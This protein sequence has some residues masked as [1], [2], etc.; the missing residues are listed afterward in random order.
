MCNLYANLM[1][2]DAMRQ[3][4]DG[5]SDKLGNQPSLPAIFPDMAV[6]ILRRTD[7]GER[8]LVQARWGYSKAKFGWVT[9]VR[10][11]KGWPWKFA[12]PEKAQ[13][14]LVPAT[15]F[16]EYH[17]SKRTEKGH[18]AAA[19]FCLEG[20]EP[21]PPFAFPGFWRTWDWAK[22]GLRTKADA[23][24]AERGETT[25]AMAFL[26]TQANG[27]V[28]PIHPKAMP[29]V[30]EPHDFDGW[31]D[32]DTEEAAA[33]QRPIADERLRLAFV[34]EKEDPGG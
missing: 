13:R 23:E 33:L 22:D 11:L 12:L 34:G 30:L 1:P 2:Q 15:S 29:V 24:R 32:A 26:T 20:E 19:W 27:V 4:F 17:P 25:L 8:E 14:C 28:A 3:L 5:A 9:N 7:E 18:K 21:R 6:P 16:A 31:L 10:N